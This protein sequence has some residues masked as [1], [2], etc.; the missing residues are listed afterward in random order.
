MA[1]VQ[2]MHRGQRLDGA[3]AQSMHRRQRVDGA[4][5]QSTHRWQTQAASSC[6]DKKDWICRCSGGRG[7]SGPQGGS[8]QR[9][10]N[11]WCHPATTAQSCRLHPPPCTFVLPLPEL[12][13]LPPCHPPVGLPT[14]PKR[15]WDS[16]RRPSPLADPPTG[17]VSSLEARKCR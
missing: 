9:T 5:A 11:S 2:G 13:T 17:M 1:E 8:R 12:Q 16:C 10:S 7:L 14:P 6:T 15:S 3:R 4:E